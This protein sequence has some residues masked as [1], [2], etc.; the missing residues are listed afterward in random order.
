MPYSQN[1]KNLVLSSCLLLAAMAG[2]AHAAVIWDESVNGLLSANYLAPTPFTLSPGTS[3]VIGIVGTDGSAI[4]PV[5]DT[6]P[7]GQDFL[8]ITIPAG[9]QLNSLVCSN[10]VSPGGDDTGFIGLV[11]GSTFISNIFDPTA[12]LGWT[13]VGTGTY[14][15]PQDGEQPVVT[16]GDNLLPIMGS[17]TFD[18]EAQGFTGPLPSGTYTLLIQQQDAD[19]YYQYDFGVSAVPEPASLGLVGLTSIGLLARRRRTAGEQPGAILCS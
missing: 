15:D 3:S 10:W 16:I 2:S 7:S 1:I 14:D 4:S 19:N 17:G 13:H 11:R 6:N 5:P 12:Y 8:S 18:Y 9:Y